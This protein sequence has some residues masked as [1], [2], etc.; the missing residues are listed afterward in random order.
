M[1]KVKIM[2]TIIKTSCNGKR[3]PFNINSNPTIAY[4]GILQMYCVGINYNYTMGI[5]LQILS[6]LAADFDLYRVSWE[7]KN[8]SRQVKVLPCR[9]TRKNPIFE[10]Q[11][12]SRLEWAKAQLA[13][14]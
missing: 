5:P 10:P 12:G 13:T 8:C 2:E 3:L 14:A 7:T 9:N 4:G 1:A 6:L 11:C